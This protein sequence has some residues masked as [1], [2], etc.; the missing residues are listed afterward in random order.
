MTLKVRQASSSTPEEFSSLSEIKDAGSN[1]VKRFSSK[2]TG[3]MTPNGFPQNLN[4]NF[5]SLF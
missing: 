5:S 1:Y 3:M 2:P 4:D